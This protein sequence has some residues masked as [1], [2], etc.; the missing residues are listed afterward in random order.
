LR[1]NREAVNDVEH[2]RDVRLEGGH[3]LVS[4]LARTLAATALDSL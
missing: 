2:R 3:N 4:D 1:S